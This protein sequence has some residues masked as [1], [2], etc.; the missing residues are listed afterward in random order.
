MRSFIKILCLLTTLVLCL[1]LSACGNKEPDVI[2]SSAESSSSEP[3]ESSEPSTNDSAD[4]NNV[5]NPLT[6]LAT[7]TKE[8]AGYKPLA[9]AINNVKVAQSIQSGVSYAD[10]VFETVTEAGIT[11]L[12]AL[13]KAPRA[14]MGRI[15]SIRSA[16]TVFADLAASMNAVYVHHGIDSTY[17]APRINALKIPRIEISTK[18]DGERVQNGKSWEHTLY[19]SGEKL[20]ADVVNKGY[21]NGNESEPWLNFVTDKVASTDSA[22][23]VT[24]KFNSAS[25]SN[26]TYNE[27]TGKYTRGSYG[28]E[29]K[30]YFTKEEATFTNVFVLYTDISLYPDNYH[31]NVKLNGGEGYYVTKGGYEKISWSKSGDYSPIAFKDASGNDL[32][33][34]PG[35][36]Y[37]CIVDKDASNSFTAE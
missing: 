7:L 37:I 14:E 29:L 23:A 19:T 32:A 4:K 34:T 11:R 36:S 24:V 17:C 18:T 8:E 33:V 31:T 2:M 21:N 30:D 9:I 15:G 20:L 6:G 22:K 25:I 13:Y 10:V 3:A 12:L 16:R 26:F 27:T 5:I 1:T 35:K 28:K